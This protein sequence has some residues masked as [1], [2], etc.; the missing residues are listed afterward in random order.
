MRG[1][2]PDGAPLAALYAQGGIAALADGSH[3]PATCPHR[4][5]PEV[6]ARIV[7]L[8]SEHPGWGPRTLLHYLAREQL[9]PLRYA[10][11]TREYLGWGVFALMRRPSAQHST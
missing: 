11:F 1:D 10:T 2:A 6:E 3:R 7:A 8:R 9:S 5:A 4:M